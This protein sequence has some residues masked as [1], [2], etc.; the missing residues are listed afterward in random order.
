MSGILSQAEIDALLKSNSVNITDDEI[1]T[2][3]EI[4]NISMGTAAT[5]LYEILGKRVDITTPKVSVTTMRKM[6]ET[7]TIPYVGIEVKYLSGVEGFS[8]LVLKMVDA[9]IITDLLMGGDGTNPGEELD[10]IRLSA[11]GEIMNQMMGS[12]A[13][14]MSE[15]LGTSVTIAPPKLFE[16]RFADTKLDNIL[17]DDEIVKISFKMVVEDIINSEIMQI[18]SK[19]YAIKFAGKLLNT[20]E[21]P[22]ENPDTIS[23]TEEVK[24]EA[25]ADREE[26]KKE[27]KATR[28]PS[29][30][31]NVSPLELKS[32]EDEDVEEKSEEVD[33]GDNLGLLMD[34]PLPITIELGRSKKMIKEILELNEG[35]VVV[36]DRF[37]GDLVDVV[38]NGKLIAKGEVVVVDENYGVRITEVLSKKSVIRKERA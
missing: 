14:S 37:A 29:A 21:E 23:E 2:L 5:T 20:G 28:Q 12:A 3:G 19:D 36:L 30:K 17:E 27:K 8:F 11:L 34:V 18:M 15:M 25:K 7:Y 4:G 35:S 26:G 22:V 33:V 16:V 31:V 13:T 6:A 9:L 10:E 38:V 24:V 32:F 1:D